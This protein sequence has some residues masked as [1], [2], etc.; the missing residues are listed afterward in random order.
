M[1]GGNSGG[2][3]PGFLPPA[4]G[5]IGGGKTGFAGGNGL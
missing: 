5:G 1:I 4:P 3:P 2:F